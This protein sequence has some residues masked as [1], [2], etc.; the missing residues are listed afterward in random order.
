M[1]FRFRNVMCGHRAV[2]AHSSTAR[3]AAPLSIAEVRRLE[4]SLATAVSTLLGRPVWYELMT[5]DTAPAEAFYTKV[6]GWTSAPF[7]KSPTPYTIFKRNEQAQ[8]AGLMK[9]PDD[10]EAPPFWAM[11]LATPKLEE[12]VADIKRRGGR[13]LSPV[14]EVPTIGRMQMVSDPQGAAFGLHQK[15]S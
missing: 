11:Y 2:V 5:T 1:S 10:M 9:R 14:I 4:V 12:T 13:D 3:I 7:D 15:K 8:V 6:L